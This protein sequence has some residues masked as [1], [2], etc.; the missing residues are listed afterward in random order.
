MGDECDLDQSVRAWP[1]PFRTRGLGSVEGTLTLT[2]EGH[3]ANQ[4]LAQLVQNTDCIVQAAQE[5]ETMIQPA[6][7][8]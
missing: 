5:K 3:H 6:H 4:M 8:L 1:H 2:V 7:D